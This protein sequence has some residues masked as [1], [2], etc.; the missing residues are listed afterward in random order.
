MIFARFLHCR[1]DA[2]AESDQALGCDAKAS[3]PGLTNSCTDLLVRLGGSFPQRQHHRHVDRLHQHFEQLRDAHHRQ[4]H[5]RDGVLEVP[6]QLTLA[7]VRLFAT[8]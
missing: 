3:D 1:R 5:R 7:P 8:P 4:H 6:L 2:A